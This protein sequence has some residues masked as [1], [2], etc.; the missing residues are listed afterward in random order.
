MRPGIITCKFCGKSFNK[1]NCNESVVN[2]CATINCSGVNELNMV[3]VAMSCWS[4]LNCWCCCNS[5]IDCDDDDAF[6]D[7]DDDDDDASLSARLAV[8][9]RAA[10]VA[11]FTLLLLVNEDEPKRACVVPLFIRTRFV[12]RKSIWWPTLFV[13]A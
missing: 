7:F 3:C 4:A 2:C 12:I 13:A 8:R 9:F 5:W 11:A 1:L 6:V 10:T